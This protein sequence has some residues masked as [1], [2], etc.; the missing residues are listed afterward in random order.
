MDDKTKEVIRQKGKEVRE[1]NRVFK[2][3]IDQLFAKKYRYS[4]RYEDTMILD[5][6]KAYINVD[7]TKVKTP[8][9]IFSYDR[10]IDSE[11]YSY[12]D[13]QAFYLRAAIP[14]VI[15]FDD[16]GKYSEEMKAKIKKAVIRH[17][18]LEYED[19]RLEWKKSLLF[20]GIVLTI[21]IAFLL[22]Y[23][24]L[25]VFFFNPRDIDSIY[26]EIICILS[27]V[28]IWQSIDNF[29]FKGHEKRVDVYNAGQLALAEVSFGSPVTKK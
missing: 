29:F 6:G 12:I 16:G 3:R 13:Q 4:L 22:T 27:W 10:R 17:Y 14:L 15:N 9:S 8:F 28:F 2:K 20:G 26:L 5:D 21:G 1:Q 7:L 11:I 19:K 24:L 25:R 18:S 23:I